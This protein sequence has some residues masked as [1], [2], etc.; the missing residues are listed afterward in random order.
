[1]EKQPLCLGAWEASPQSHDEE[2][3]DEV[4][5]GAMVKSRRKS[6]PGRGKA[7]CKA[8]EMGCA[9]HTWRRTWWLVWRGGKRGKRGKHAGSM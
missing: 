1:V 4:Q 6:G 8:Q 2:R 9:L 7:R 5:V 3:P